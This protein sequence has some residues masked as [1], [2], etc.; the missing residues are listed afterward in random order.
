MTN[1]P[2]LSL[3]S[4]ITP[5]KGGCAALDEGLEKKEEEGE[6][7]KEGEKGTSKIRQKISLPPF[8]GWGRRGRRQK[9]S[10]EFHDFV[11]LPFPLV[12]CGLV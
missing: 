6:G 12:C 7:K 10:P 9:W 3:V 8:R 5:G 11:R 4:K 2:D 1:E